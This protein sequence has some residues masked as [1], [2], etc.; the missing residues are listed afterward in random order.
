MKRT[1]AIAL[2]AIFLFSL[3][4]C[5]N[6]SQGDWLSED[7]VVGTQ[8]VTIPKDGETVDGSVATTAGEDAQGTG[9]QKG[10]KTTVKGDETK[11]SADKTESGKTEGVVT[12]GGQTRTRR[13]TS[14]TKA[15][16]SKKTTIRTFKSRPKRTYPVN[17]NILVTC[18]GDSIT[19]GQ[20]FTDPNNSPDIPDNMAGALS[21]RYTVK[22]YG[23]SGTTAMLKGYD[24]GSPKAYMDT[25][26]YQNSL[27]PASDIVVI[28]LGTNDAKDY[29]WEITPNAKGKHFKDSLIRLVTS[30][31][32]LPSAPTVILA[33]PPKIFPRNYEWVP[34]Y[35]T[36][37]IIPIIKEVAQLTGCPVADVYEA[38]KNATMDDFKDGIHPSTLNARKMIAHTIADAIKRETGVN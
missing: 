20:Y 10:D 12:G 30:Y 15:P 6:A 27:R 37:E 3:V 8:V 36:D 25:I 34:A 9:E 28:M 31:Q 4:A 13:T 26:E 17:K 22:G 29:N 21:G 35:L 7:V 11:N 32:D 38:T 24:N 18:I 14:T 23:V 1:L 5:Q 33:T 2:V 16:T 19:A